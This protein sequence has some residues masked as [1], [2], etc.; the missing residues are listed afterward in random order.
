MSAPDPPTIVSLLDVPVID[1]SDDD[2]EKSTA[3]KL[4]AVKFMIIAKISLELFLV[5][6][7]WSVYPLEPWDIVIES[8]LIES[9]SITSVPSVK[10][11]IISA[12]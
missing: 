5:I 12:K 2:V 7:V 6:I 11:V 9:S 3:V 10:S 1:W 4:L 8:K